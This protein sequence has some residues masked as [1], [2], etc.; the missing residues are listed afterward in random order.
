MDSKNLALLGRSLCK[1]QDA[2]TSIEYALLASL[3]A[4]AVLGVVALV[5][6]HTLDLWSLVQKC[7]SFAVNLSG[8]CP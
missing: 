6:Q 4:M 5:G 8:S 2:V 1:E 7:V 3:I